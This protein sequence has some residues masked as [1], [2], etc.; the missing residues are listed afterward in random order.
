MCRRVW[1]GPEI[2]SAGYTKKQKE[3][4]QKQE[5][6]QKELEDTAPHHL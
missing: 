5:R 2:G 4:K 3:V 6:K 1:H